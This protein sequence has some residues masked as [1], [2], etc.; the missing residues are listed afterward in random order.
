MATMY[1]VEQKFAV[2]DLAGL[3]RRVE[4]RGTVV[5]P[6]VVQLDCYFNH[7]QR[8]FAQTDEAFRI[9]VDGDRNCV[10]YKGPRISSNTKTRREIEF[11]IGD[12]RET[13]EQL[14]EMLVALG[15]REVATVK[16]LRRLAKLKHGDWQVTMTFDDVEGV[17][18]FTELEVLAEENQLGA[19]D[20]LIQQLAVQWDLAAVERRSYLEMLLE[21]DD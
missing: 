20:K 7:P 11:P 4:A 18:T 16:K 21:R 13:R 15:F 10:T 2:E 6:E 14:T 17:G 3:R 12:G 8:D 1:E 19:A 5:G 9:R